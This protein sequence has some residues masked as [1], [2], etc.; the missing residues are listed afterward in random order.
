MLEGATFRRGMSFDTQVRVLHRGKTTRLFLLLFALLGVLASPAVAHTRLKSVDY[1]GLTLRVPAGWPVFHL[2][3]RSTVC[4]RFNRH[5]VY[6][7][8]PGSAQACPVGSAG[9]TEA[10]LVQPGAHA[11][12]GVY[13]AD[14]T[15]RRTRGLTVTAT[16]RAHPDAI[17]TALGVVR[18]PRAVAPRPAASVRRARAT[19]V[20]SSAAPATP[21]AVFAGDGFD[22]CATP[23]TSTMSAWGAASP[24][25]AVGVYIGGENMACAQPNLNSTWMA[26]ES[27]AGWHVVPIYVGL[28]S[29]T[30][31][32]GCAPITASQASAEGSAAA[33][34]AVSDAG[35]VGIGA[36]NPLYY[37]MEG[38]SRNATNS[39]AV[40]AFLEAWT[41][42]LHAAGYVSGVY[43]SDASGI[44]DLAAQYGTGYVEP[45]DIWIAAW[46]NQANTVDSTIPTA[47]WP[48]NQR[49]HQYQG[50]TRET[51]G[52]VTVDVDN[53]YVAGATAAF[54]GGGA[55]AAAPVAV[56]P[57]DSAAPTIEGVPVAGQTLTELHGSWSGSP[58]S[59]AYG[60]YRCDARQTSCAP[61]PGA[62]GETYTLTPADVNA[63]IVVAEVAANAVG[64]GTAVTSAPTSAVIRAAAGYWSFTARGAVYNSEYQLLWG[65]P[66]D[67]GLKDFVGMAATPGR[68]GYWMVTK[69]ATV[70]AYGNAR[71][72]PAIHVAHPLIG[73]VRAPDLGYWLYTASGNV[74]AASG[75][76]FYGSPARRHL[77][78]VSGMAATPSGNGYWV[79]TR[80]GI[81]YPFGKA[82]LHA[83]IRPARPVIGIVA[84]PNHGYWLYTASGNVYPSTGA[85]Y[86]GSP[87]GSNVASMLATPDGRGYWLITHTG[88]VYAYGDAANYPDP[89][90]TSGAV[91]GL[92][93]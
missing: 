63:T 22:T 27:A 91:V 26:S 7:G 4:V 39:A 30:N 8:T 46:N 28:Q 62:S 71:S 54:G 35:T 86:Y 18:L 6:L 51:Y 48:T 5:A 49:L 88:K 13:G 58:T 31:S 78:N 90:L 10:I 81:V 50:A 9:R 89:T 70:Y 92:A 87:H 45:D 83:R 56:A 84:A 80:R 40:L 17:R 15:V 34:D 14:A 3:A 12:G 57:A 55:V 23:S 1:R 47:D 53:D 85:P 43:S 25:G 77:S 93:G 67:Y 64:P 24:Y 37:D 75:T 52:G 82:V 42:G 29:P 68:H 19:R 2:S 73:I 66:S 61:I 36:G 59:Y 69:F 65:S 79:V 33:V 32:C 60:W 16:W 21:G 72:H 74:Y 38:Y 44:A 11:A 20:V 41:E 76:P